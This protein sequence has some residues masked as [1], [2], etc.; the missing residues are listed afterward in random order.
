[1][2]RSRTEYHFKLPRRKRIV[3]VSCRIP[4]G[5]IG[6]GFFGISVFL[7]ISRVWWAFIPG[8]TA[9]F[10]ARGFM[11][12]LTRFIL[13]KHEDMPQRGQ[14]MD[15]CAILSWLGSIIGTAFIA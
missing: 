4:L 6:L 13:R 10:L 11:V 1:M 12:A 2:S 15:L 7:L 3:G 9:L 5:F 8:L 14:T